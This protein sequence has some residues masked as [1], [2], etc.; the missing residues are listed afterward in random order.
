MSRLTSPLFV[1]AV[2]YLY[3]GVI[4]IVFYTENFYTNNSFFSWG[5]P[6]KFFNTTILT[7]KSFYTLQIL[8]FFHQ[9]VNNMVNSVVYPWILNSVQDPKNRVMQYP[10]WVCIFLV[11]AFDLYSELDMILIIMGFTS[12]ISFIVTIV[13]AN[14]ITSTIINWKYLLSKQECR[15]PFAN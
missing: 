7:Y 5:P 14:L 12:Q 4:G 11:N 2:A 3:V 6:V 8:I 15:I 10:N 13:S 1:I 9:I